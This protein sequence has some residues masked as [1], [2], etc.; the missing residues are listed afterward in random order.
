[1]YLSLQI[2]RAL[3]ALMVVCF[4]VS[5]HLHRADHLGEAAAWAHRLCSFGDAGVPFFFVLSGFIVTRVHRHEF[6]RPARALPYL[7]KRATRIYP[8]Y[9]LVFGITYVGLRLMSPGNPL[10]P[11]D[12]PSLLQAI[13][14]LPQR[15][16]IPGV[17]SA[18]VVF[19]AWTLQYEIAFYAILTLAFLHKWWLGVLLAL[20]LGNRYGF[21]PDTG[22]MGHFMR[23]DLVL[24]LAIGTALAL[25]LPRRPSSRWPAIMLVIV[26]LSSFVAWA[27]WEIIRYPA[28]LSVWRILAY[29]LASS[30]LIMGLAWME[31]AGW[32]PSRDG[33]WV[34]LGDAS[35]SLY[36]IHAPWMSLATLPVLALERHTHVISNGGAW[37]G[38]LATAAIALSAC[39]VALR[40]HVHIERPLT[41]LAK[42]LAARFTA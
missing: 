28:E 25:L 5:G 26:G 12:L 10:L 41:L 15:E 33:L 19:V 36:L 16:P 20:E 18:H 17:M 42:R 21:M 9:W 27:L 2:C 1:M 4:H 11:Q 37:G 3:A 32:R 31:D 14:L 39:W 40:W 24:L 22:W 30:A 7:I 29:G 13:L 35:Y 6:N 38:G 23:N 8:I 34:R